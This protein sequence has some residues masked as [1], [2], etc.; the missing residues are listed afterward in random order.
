MSFSFG[1]GANSSAIEDHGRMRRFLAV[2]ALFTG[3]HF[4]R[5]IIILCVSWYTS[6]R[7]SFRDLVIMMADRGISLAHTTILRWVQHYLPEFE[8]RWKRYA[9]AVGGSWR[10]DET[11][12]E[13]R[14]RWAYLYRAVDKAGN[15]VDFFLSR[16]RDV[17]AAKGFLRSAMKNTRKPTKI[18]LDACAALHRAVREIKE[19][20]ELPQRVKVRS[21]QY[22]N[23]LIEQDHR[24]VKHRIGPM[25]GFK[26]FENAVVTISGIELAEK[27]KKG[28]FKT[29]KL[30]NQMATMS[31]RWNAALA[32]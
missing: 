30:G 12:I 19:D 32:A 24:R 31:E 25:L 17:D 27:I 11:Y 14:G 2:E 6:F 16:K 5:Q 9:R 10:M 22:L 23:N 21:S 1:S 13:V 20:G 3:R 7:L 8:K 26:R 4:D 29:G 28:Q 15:T 18:T